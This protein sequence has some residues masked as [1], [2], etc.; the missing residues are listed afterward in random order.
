M[1]VLDSVNKQN[2]LAIYDSG[3]DRAP[4]ARS[5]GLGSFIDFG[6]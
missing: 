2:P 6:Q 3:I 1:A 5:E 4:A